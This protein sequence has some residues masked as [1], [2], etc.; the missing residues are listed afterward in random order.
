MLP[1]HDQVAGFHDS[2]IFK[3]LGVDIRLRPYQHFPELAVIFKQQ[4][5]KK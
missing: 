3:S 2:I 1:E 5:E 4:K